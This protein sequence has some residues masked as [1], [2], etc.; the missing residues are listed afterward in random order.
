MHSSAALLAFDSCSAR[1]AK[2]CS[3]CERCLIVSRPLHPPSICCLWL[4][5]SE[6]QAAAQLPPPPPPQPVDTAQFAALCAAPPLQVRAFVRACAMVG[7]RCACLRSAA[8]ATTVCAMQP[9][10]GGWL[11]SVTALFAASHPT[12]SQS[13]C[14]LPV[15]HAFDP[16]ARA[17]TGPA[18][19]RLYRL[20]CRARRRAPA[21]WLPLMPSL[22]PSAARRRASRAAWRCS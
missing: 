4:Q 1:V 8:R 11:A 17:A 19:A 21:S 2:H 12:A 5:V 16:Y 6:L 9:C 14:R 13:S 3:S 20:R 7:G 18:G 10:R 22:L 15:A